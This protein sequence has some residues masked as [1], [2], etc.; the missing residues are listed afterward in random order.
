MNTSSSRPTIATGRLIGRPRGQRLAHD[1]ARGAV[2]LEHLLERRERGADRRAS[3]ARSTSASMSR[4]A[5]AAGHERRDRLLVGGVQRARR[6]PARLARGA[7]EREAAE[8][9]GVGRLEA[10]SRGPAARSSRGASATARAVGMRERVGDRHAHVG[11]ARGARAARRRA[12]ARARARSTCG[13]TTTSMRSYG[14]PNSR[15]ASITSKPLFISV[16]ES[17]V[18]RPPIAQVGWRS[19]SATLTSASSAARAPA[20]RA[21]RGRD[22]QR[23]D[24]AGRLVPQQLVER[25]VLGVDRHER[26]AAAGGRREH[27]VAAGDEALLVRERDVDAGLERG[28]RRAQARDADAGVQHEVGATPRRRARRRP[29]GPR[30]RCPRSP[31]GPARRPRDRRARAP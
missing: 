5:A 10:Q 13:C 9:L 14:T 27:E 25:R 28:E 12:G 26:G 7:R 20:E 23:L 3:S 19:A 22:D 21:A 2:G 15:C 1:L 16:A 30:A 17:I 6:E 29:R 18:M 8:H 11:Q 4:N 31:R 24:G